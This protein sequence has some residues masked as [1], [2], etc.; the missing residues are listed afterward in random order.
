VA[1]VF[2]TG[3]ADG[4][5]KMAAELLIAQGHQVVLHG[6]NKKRAKEA[7]EAVRRQR[8]PSWAISAASRKPDQSPNR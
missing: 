5:G 4:L 7:L 3:S 6:R 8:P 2:I 1:R